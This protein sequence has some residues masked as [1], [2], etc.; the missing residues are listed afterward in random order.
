LVDNEGKNTQMRKLLAAMAVASVVG[1][2]ASAANAT[3][4]FTLG[5]HPQ[6]DEENILFQAP[7][8]GTSIDGAT[9][10]G[11]GV[12]FSTLTGQ[13]LFQKA[14][15][16]ADIFAT[17]QHPLD[18]QLTSMDVTTP[19]YLFGDFILNLVNGQ[20][21]ATVT[22][23]TDFNAVLVYTLGNGQ[24]F[25]TIVASNGELI[26]EIQVTMSEGGGFDQFKQ[27]RISGL[28]KEDDG[29]CIPV[30]VPEPATLALLGV[31][32]A[33]LGLFWRWRSE[34]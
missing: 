24:N 19:G 2:M 21:D 8:S 33:G 28:C 13:T 25:L 20:G 11:V 3:I 5:N 34:T 22:V 7:Q 17:D 18:V 26:S 16:Q 14:Q 4:T 12:V 30:N 27:P 32:L 31:G 15:G 23:I 6:P 1:L 10:S 29:G 9:Q